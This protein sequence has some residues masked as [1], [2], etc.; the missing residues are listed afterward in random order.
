MSL[1]LLLRA[2]QTA[3]S[4]NTTEADSQIGG[5]GGGSGW[6]KNDEA[7]YTLSLNRRIHQ[8]NSALIAMLAEFAASGA[9]EC[10]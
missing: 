3:T 1:L 9:L 10:H 6:S 5:S 7:D 4:V 2:A 8:Q